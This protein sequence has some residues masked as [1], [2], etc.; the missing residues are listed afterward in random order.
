[1]RATTTGWEIVCPDPIGSAV[2]SQAAS[3]RPLGTNR[4]RGTD[5]IAAKTRSS[6]I[7][8]R[9]WSTSRSA[10]AVACAM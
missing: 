2:F 7:C 8:G 3:A 9:S 4:S 5:A 6:R 1:M 10:V